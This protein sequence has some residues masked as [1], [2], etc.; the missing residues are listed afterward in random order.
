MSDKNYMAR[1]IRLAQKGLYTTNPNPRVGCVLVKDGE[2]VG[3]G[4]HKKAGEAHAEI[5]ALNQ[6]GDRAEGAT[7][8]VTL[9][10]CSHQGKTPPC[11]DALIKARV[12][13]VVAAMVDPN[14][15]VSGSGLKKLA[16]AG[17]ATES[18]VLGPQA[19]E[20]NPGFIKRMATGLPWVRIKLAMSLDG[21]T[22]M[23]SGES[24]WISGAEAREDVQK[25]RARS[26]AILTGTGTVIADD[27]SLNVR[28]SSEALGI[29][30]APLQPL[31]VIIDSQCKTPK[32]AK[33][34]DL[35]GQTI[36]FTSQPESVDFKHT[37]LEVITVD[38]LQGKVD[39]TAALKYLAEKEVNEVHV[40]AGSVLCGALLQQQLVDE[41]I[42]YMAPHIMGDSAKG[43]FHLPGLDQMKQ[44]IDL[45]INDIR[46]IGKDWRI[47]A[48]PKY[49]E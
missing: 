16:A 36:I 14:P 7:A 13:R 40:E 6:A 39:L 18:G 23:A 44:R 24:K 22:A 9:E 32:N 38:D 4:W 11:A 49:Q 29:D 27:P 48:R 26:S 43:L 15:A 45:E 1:A 37:N 10:P 47:T 21:R 30:T 35:P 34:L 28:A 33:M 17:I 31:R 8:Y 2:I 25:L 41:I 3:E 42:V 19:R 20:L 46:P 5:N 12:A